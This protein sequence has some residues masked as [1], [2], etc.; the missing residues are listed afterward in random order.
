MVKRSRAW[1]N[2]Q[3]RYALAAARFTLPHGFATGFGIGAI[4]SVRSHTRVERLAPIAG[5]N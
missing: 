1:R 3:R 4:R 2:R 5:Y